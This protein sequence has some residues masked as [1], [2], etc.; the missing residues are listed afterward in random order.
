MLDA[1]EFG[2]WRRQAAETRIAA[3]SVT[4][5]SSWG[6]C[7][8]MSEQAAQLAVKALLHATGSPSRAWGHDLVAL[9]F[10]AGQDL[11]GPLVAPATADAAARLSRHY[12]PARY[13]DA[14]SGGTPADHYREA[15]ALDALADTDLVLAAV[16]TV[17]ASMMRAEEI[18]PTEVSESAPE[19]LP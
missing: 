1:D 11:G 14:H 7:C 9:V 5:A 17:W 4:A 12:I 2:R 19:A 10:R 3:E 6:W 13:P 16:D 15:D 8:F 18:P